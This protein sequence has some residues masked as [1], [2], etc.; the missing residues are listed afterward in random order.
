MFWKRVVIIWNTDLVSQ[1][2]V[3]GKNVVKEEGNVC[4]KIELKSVR[5]YGSGDFI[6]PDSFMSKRN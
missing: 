6:G 5:A 1:K 4:R 3:S 2:V